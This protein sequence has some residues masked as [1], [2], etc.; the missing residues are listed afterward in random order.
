[1]NSN[2]NTQKGKQ[3]S[4]TLT[5]AELHKIAKELRKKSRMSYLQNRS[6]QQL[7]L[8]KRR[9]ED[10]DKL[11]KGVRLSEDEINLNKINKNIYNLVSEKINEADLNEARYNLPDDVDEE[12]SKP[13]IKDKKTKGLFD[14]YTE[15]NKEENEDEAW[16]NAQK[17]RTG[18]KYGALNNNKNNDSYDLLIENQVDFVKNELYEGVKKHL[19][20]ESDSSQSISDDES[21][22]DVST[23]IKKRKITERVKTPYELELEKIQLDRQSLPVYQYKDDLLAAIRD[24]QV[25]IIQGETGSGKTTQI[26]QYLNEIGYTRNNKKIAI[27][28]PRR[29]AAMSVA[30]RVAYEMNVKCG[31]DV[32]YS[33]RFEDCTSIQTK[34]KY[35][36]DGVFLRE[37]LTDPNLSNYS[38]IM[39][40]EAHERTLY[41]DVIF[42]L[43][44]DLAKYRKD[45]KILISSATLE[46]EKFK[47]YFEE[48][49][50]FKIPGRRY[51][52]DIYYT[53]EPEADY[54]E[55]SVVTA[56]Q[57]HLTQ[58]VNGDIL[59][60]LTGQE[61]IE[62]ARE[63]IYTRTK[64]LKGKIPNFVV[65]P[66]YSALPSEE[67]AKIFLP[68]GENERKIILATNIAETSITINGIVY[69]IDCG[70]AKQM[71]FNPRNGLETLAVAPISKAS[72][73]QRAGRAGRVGPGKCFRLYTSYS[74][75]H[76]LDSDNIP[77][78][79]RTN[80][81]SV[82]LL[83]KSLGIDDLLHFDFIDPPPN[84]ILIRALEQLYAL[85]ALNN[86]GD[87]T[88]LGRKMA[89]FPLDPCL[90]KAILSSINYK[91]LD[92]ILTISAVLSVGANIF[93][94]SKDN[95]AASDKSRQNFFRLGGDHFTLLSV[96]NEWKETDYSG[97]WCRDNYIH[98][99]SMRKAR[100]I[101][102]Q[103]VSLCEKVGINPDDES[104]SVN[105]E[106]TS[107]NI[108]KAIASGFFYNSAHLSKDGVYRTIKNAHVVNIHPTSSL[109]KDN[110]RWVIYHELV[111][112]TKE[113]MREIIEIEPEW[114][115]E[116]APHYYKNI[117]LS[118]KD[119]GK[120]KGTN[121]IN[122]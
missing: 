64:G 100:D 93:Y 37:L 51:H 106:N 22:L 103:L 7:D 39:I 60:F 105:D 119:K 49:P 6:T 36:T 8:L 89:E 5:D 74:Y 62:T 120:N 110:P 70:F 83:L 13:Y 2:S 82:V 32:G 33:I 81:S 26:P 97:A 46:G 14:R 41:T 115:M 48:A 28:Q 87:L 117:D 80:L 54:I 77:E 11:F 9:I 24:N 25:L 23:G 114:L 101:K 61:E 15:K 50:L 35:M 118:D 38:V 76:E 102:E 72:A 68:A 79:Q 21:P 122:Y 12:K 121:K 34:I 3:N 92:Q 94:K 20:N 90:S 56:L 84:E 19:E 116:V 71:S 40:D 65:L 91:C 111:Y 109:I 69:V 107:A 29:V 78:I 16:E 108:R 43:I 44:K 88:K 63:M 18:I 85:G 67:Q 58:P 42:G 104:L 96:F 27:T 53:K 52:V 59:V 17:K 30:A 57:I 66:I 95:E 47:E 73:K 55:A 75:Q 112:T 10:E 86:E 98:F 31:H 113:Y 99:K 4:A 45:I 1:M